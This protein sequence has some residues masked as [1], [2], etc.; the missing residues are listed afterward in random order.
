[1]EREPKDRAEHSEKADPKPG[2]RRGAAADPL[3]YAP[4]N[5]TIAGAPVFSRSVF[6]YSTHSR[7]IGSRGPSN[8]RRGD[9]ASRFVALSH[10]EIP[11]F[12]EAHRL[13]IP[14]FPSVRAAFSR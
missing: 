6:A 13:L 3:P 11:R 12:S 4:G 14:F 1:M 9:R 8:E 7:Q 2:R 10:F 5:G